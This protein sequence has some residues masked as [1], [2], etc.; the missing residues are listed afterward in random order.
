MGVI[1]NAGGHAHVR[2]QRTNP[3][4][5]VKTMIRPI[6]DAIR[7]MFKAV[8]GSPKK[9]EVVDA[10]RLLALYKNMYSELEA[11]AARAER[12]HGRKSS[13]SERE[14]AS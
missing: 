10:T 13:L 7:R 1:V 5:E 12:K 3:S 6:R 14:D 9:P 11:I 8:A 2:V 4:T